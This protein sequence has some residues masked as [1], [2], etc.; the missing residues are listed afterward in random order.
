[1]IKY[2]DISALASKTGL[3]AFIAKN[4]QGDVDSFVREFSQTVSQL[5]HT[6]LKKAGKFV[7]RAEVI[8]K[9]LPGEFKPRLLTIQARFDHWRGESQSALVKYRRAIELLTD[10]RRFELAN[11]TRMGLMDVEM[12]LGQYDNALA[13]GRKALEYFRRRG[14]H[15]FAARVLTN[16]G[17]V[18]HRLDNNR[19]ALRQ[20][21]RAREI[22]KTRG[23]IPLAIVDYNR[24]NIFSNLGEL[25]QAQKLYR[26][27]AEI[28]KQAGVG[29]NAVK[30][31]YSL[32]YL[33]FLSDKYT[34]A[35]S[36][37]ESAYENFMKLG[38]GKSAAAAYLDQA[39]M[40]ITLHQYG[41]SIALCKKVIEL[42]RQY[43]LGYEEGKAH[44]FAAQSY[45]KLGEIN[46]A[47]K[48]L[49]RAEAL[50]TR[51]NNQHWLGMIRY[52]KAAL[53][54]DS[55]RYQSA[56]ESAQTARRLFAV[57]GDERRSVEAQL[58]L[59]EISLRSGN[60][61][62][63]LKKAEALRQC[64]LLSGQSYT[65]NKLL[66]QYYFKCE[67]YKQASV[68]YRRAIDVTEKT[69]MNLYPDEIRFF[70]ALGQTEVYLGLIECLLKQNKI[71]QSFMVN[72]QVLKIINQQA[73]PIKTGS[74][75]VPEKY[76]HTR[77][78]L[79]SQL[80]E[81]S[82]AP[83]QGQRRVQTVVDLRRT[84][85]ELWQTEQKIKAKL[86]PARR[87][88]D[89]RPLPRDYYRRYLQSDE[90]LIN[91]VIINDTLNAYIVRQN[92][93]D[94]MELPGTASELISI[95]RELHFL[96]EKSV[97]FSADYDN[98]QN[99][100]ENYQKQL[101]NKLIAP[102]ALTD[103]R[104]GLIFLIDDIFTQIPWA[105]LQDES[106]ELLYR[107]YKFNLIVNP[108]DLAGRSGRERL[109]ID[110]QS[111]VF[112]PDNAG[113]PLIYRELENIKKVFPDARTYSGETADC[114][115]LLENMAQADG[116]VHI[117]THASRSSENP[118]FSR[119][120][121]NDGPLFP[122]DLF[123]ANIKSRLVTLSGCQTAA[124]GIY[125]GNSFSLARAFYQA[126]AANV[127]A[128]LWPISDKVSLVFMSEFYS[129]LAQTGD[130][131]R[132]YR[133]AIDR[134]RT[135][136]RNPA[137]WSPFVLLGI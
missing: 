81:F 125:Y 119:I 42:Y 93:V 126:G 122:F 62:G 101:W 82:R 105:A 27:T 9:Y 87:R 47:R 59:L 123:G 25:E 15:N 50:F 111:A 91:Y 86:Y 26:A 60:T 79:R 32:A 90:I 1:M 113:L 130:I 36:G 56:V 133:A 19:M 58:V 89:E 43:K 2:S 12:Y 24:A 10:L 131:G 77:T 64:A 110:N 88:A 118:L 67:D 135:I 121:M 112:A 37:F 92:S 65:L 40:Y 80:K 83:Q 109:S 11:T 44:Y 116:F 137:F 84:E 5:L 6:D 74:K 18:Y 69:L 22:F 95:I 33:Y 53:D 120:L 34:A 28:Y 78:R 134:T 52:L 85:E 129:A 136:N 70:F 97:H 106:G 20:Y 100:I 124:P 39:E 127:L 71:E 8:F 3:D 14:N 4:Y 117:A 21:D 16:L 96:M 54:T 23:G 114:R 55:K 30:A 49:R 48:Y 57:S 63:F 66:G 98:T 31:E 61:R 17:N 13:T 68:Y 94:F 29:I 41:A 76:Y 115:N 108:A 45:H 132:A 51:E 38:D 107:K 128:S 46:T 99:I 102:L 72:S 73:A 103:D 7:A 104:A 75:N 35:M